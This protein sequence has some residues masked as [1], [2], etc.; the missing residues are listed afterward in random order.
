MMPFGLWFA[1]PLLEM[2]H[3]AKITRRKFMQIT[4]TAAAVSPIVSC[5]E[6]KRPW[7]FFT[8]AE[9]QTLGAICER[10]IPADQDPGAGWAGVV[11][12]LDLQLTGPYRKFRAT[13]RQGLAGTDQTSQILF[14]RRF[15]DLDARQQDD[16][17]RA[18]EKGRA[19]GDTWKRLSA[20]QFFDLVLTHTMQGFYGD[21]RHGGNREGVSWRMLGLPYPPIRGRL[22]YDLSRPGTY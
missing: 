9:A 7:R 17:L 21:P 3:R 13:Y 10:L 15:A 20:E 4:A 1:R 11:N 2:S 14:E 6:L 12:F 18:L 5:A 19:Q 8:E 16:V 22:R